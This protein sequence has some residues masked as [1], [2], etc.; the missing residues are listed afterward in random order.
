MQKIFFSL[1]AATFLQAEVYDGVAVVIQ[2]KM[3]TL[4]D[5]QQEMQQDKVGVKRATDLLIRQKLE[6][7]ELQK[8]KITVGSSEVYADI[9]QLAQRNH[10]SVGEFYDAV[11]ETNGLTSEQLKEKIKQKLLSQKLYSAI[12]MSSLAEPSDDEVAEYYELHKESLRHPL[13]FDV[14]IYDARDKRVLQ[15]KANNPMFYSP[16]IRSNE[17]TLPYNRIS[18][19]LASLLQKTQPYHFTPVIP[20]GK[21]GFMTFYLKSVQTAQNAPLQ[22]VKGEIINT[23]MEKK[24]EAVLSDYFARLKNN[25][26]INV[27][28]LPKE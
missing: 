12:A 23:L 13:S 14:I 21:G 11:R 4:Y 18:P 25:T 10:L 26:D 6:A 28:R 8:R 27:I 19:E 20:N 24:R 7:I 2:D 15:T 3:I 5:I 16:E 1:L 9:K 22:E 17:Q